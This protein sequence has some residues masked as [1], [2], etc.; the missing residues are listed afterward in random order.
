MT[1][2]SEFAGRLAVVTGGGRGI[3]KAIAQGLAQRG[4]Q[5]HVFDREAA[6][7]MSPRCTHH[8][9]DVSRLEDVENA[10]RSLPA[11]PTLLVNNAGITRD[12]SLLKMDAD[13]WHAVI[14]VN[15]T[16][17]FN[18]IRAAAP[19]MIAEGSGRI[20]N[21]SSINGLRGKFGQGNYAA[22]KAGLIGLTKTAARE[23]GPKGITVNAVAPG[24]V[25]TDMT[26]ALPEEFRQRAL[27][28]AVL[29]EL[30]APEDV[31][32]AVIFLLSDGAR[33]I[34]GQVLKVDSGQYI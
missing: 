1:R 4:A 14:S 32:E 28:E 26:L 27:D 30:P 8:K 11:K 21:I 25:T 10:M 33:R 22:A 6:T 20:V 15:L 3:G 16:G 2:A 24:M 12:R 13:E 23:L 18:M 17:A 9:V 31:A 5:V 34:T 29:A 19:L 7:D